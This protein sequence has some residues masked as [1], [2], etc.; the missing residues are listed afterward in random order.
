M[1]TDEASVRIS[2][3]EASVLILISTGFV[4]LGATTA[5]ILQPTTEQHS[6]P[7][8]HIPTPDVVTSHGELDQ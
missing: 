7:P 4:G 1:P 2:T 5:I 8:S 6:P 3:M